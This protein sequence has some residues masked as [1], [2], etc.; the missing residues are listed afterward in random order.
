MSLAHSSKF[1]LCVGE[2]L[3]VG[4]ACHEMLPSLFTYLL[5]GQPDCHSLWAWSDH[6]VIVGA[7]RPRMM[8]WLSLP[9][10]FTREKPACYSR[11]LSSRKLL[12]KTLH[13][14]SCADY[15]MQITGV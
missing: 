3:P 8:V 15:G 9:P 10:C 2:L 13:V 6:R 5:A 4:A 1:S 14:S 7:L 11:L 12:L